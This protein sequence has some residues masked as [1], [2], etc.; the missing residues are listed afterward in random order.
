MKLIRMAVRDVLPTD[1]KTPEGINCVAFGSHRVGPWRFVMFYELAYGLN[2][3]L[4]NSVF[5]TPDQP[6]YT[7][8]VVKAGLPMRMFYRPFHPRYKFF[9][10]RRD[11]EGGE[12]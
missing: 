7:A 6:V 4:T 9:Y 12:K 5:P 8:E 10:V 1:T 2:Y 3:E 11:E